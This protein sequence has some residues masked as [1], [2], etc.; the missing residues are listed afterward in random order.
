MPRG[1]L[2]RVPQAA[3]LNSSVRGIDSLQTFSGSYAV[4]GYDP[5]GNFK[6]NWSYNMVGN[7]PEGHATTTF[8]APIIPVSVLMLNPDGTPRYLSGQ[9]LYS[10]ATKYTS[11]VL[12]S[13]I[14]AKYTYTSSRTPT[15]FVDAVQRAES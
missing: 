10:D 13:P 1:L 4:F 11:K 12:E 9:L 8:G 14:F 3:R 2:K 7:A 5:S 6:T 15:Q